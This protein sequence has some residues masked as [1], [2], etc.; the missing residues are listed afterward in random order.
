M[1]KAFVVTLWT[2]QTHNRGSQRDRC[3]ILAPNTMKSVKI[4]AFYKKLYAVYPTV[5]ILHFTP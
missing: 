4:A 2:L 5:F 3:E 1:L